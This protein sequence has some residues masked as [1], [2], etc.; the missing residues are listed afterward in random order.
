MQR[1][2]GKLLDARAAWDEQLILQASPVLPMLLQALL[3]PV[4][5]RDRARWRFR[6]QRGASS[7]DFFQPTVLDE[8]ADKLA[9]FFQFL[10]IDTIPA[11]AGQAP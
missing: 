8:V 11:G 4:K 10:L 6:A 5:H 3:G 1:E 2:V 9:V 7:R